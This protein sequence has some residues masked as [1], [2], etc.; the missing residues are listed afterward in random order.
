MN[1]SDNKELTASE[2]AK[3]FGIIIKLYAD[4]QYNIRKMLS[5]NIER[6]TITDEIK[7][8][9]I[10][11]EFNETFRKVKGINFVESNFLAIIQAKSLENIFKKTL[12]EETTSNLKKIFNF[13]KTFVGIDVSMIP[14]E[15]TTNEFTNNTVENIDKSKL[16]Q[17]QVVRNK[18]AHEAVWSMWFKNKDYIYCEKAFGKIL[19]EVSKHFV[20]N[21]KN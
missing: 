6:I 7:S 9:V 1:L 15:K 17:F 3:N 19:S 16:I 5:E 2:E 8:K 10:S 18:I 14:F 11:A 12:L 21:D 20:N 13:L 4:F